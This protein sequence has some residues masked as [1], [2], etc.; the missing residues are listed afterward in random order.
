MDTLRE[1]EA[2]PAD[3][4]AFEMFERYQALVSEW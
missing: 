4:D 2:V 3:D 1:M